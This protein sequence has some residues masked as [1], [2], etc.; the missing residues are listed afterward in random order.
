[1]ESTSLS[2]KNETL[3]AFRIAAKDVEDFKRMAHVYHKKG[4]IKISTLSA[5]GKKAL[6][7]SFNLWKRLEE[8]KT[9]AIQLTQISSPN[10]P[11]FDEKVVFMSF[12]SFGYGN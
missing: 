2:S 1:M 5:L 10:L 6:Y 9:L 3:V 11:G 4:D 12:T 8:A 7:W